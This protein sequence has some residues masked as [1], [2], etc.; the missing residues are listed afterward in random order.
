MIVRSANRSAFR[1]R[2]AFTLLEVLVVVAI[3]V[4]LASVAGIGVFRFLEDAKADATTLKMQALEKA[5]KAYA[6][7][8]DGNPPESLNE[9]LF[10]SDGAEPFIEGG[11]ASIM[12]T[13]GTPINYEPRAIDPGGSPSPVFRA[14]SPD[15]KRHVVWPKWAR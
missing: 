9:L 11:Q 10:P 2:D 4:I 14:Q 8:N 15:G 3:L 12:S 6:T 1:K 7:K 13:W 5:C